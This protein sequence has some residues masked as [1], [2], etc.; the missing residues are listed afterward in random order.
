MS[1]LLTHFWPGATEEQYRT[2]MAAVHPDG[3]AGLPP[4]QLHHAAAHTEDGIVIIAVWDSKESSDRFV[5]DTL[6]PSM[7]ADGFQGQ[8][9]ERAATIFNSIAI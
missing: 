4:G 6:L 1:Y 8:P 5:S 2:T 3:G 9:E 7:P